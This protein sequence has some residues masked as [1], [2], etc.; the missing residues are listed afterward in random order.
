MVQFLSYEGA[1]TATDGPAAGKTSVD[2]GV[3]ETNRTAETESLQLIGA[4]TGL[5]DF[6]WTGPVPQSQGV[7]NDGQT[8]AT[9][10]VAPVAAPIATLDLGTAHIAPNPI[11]DR[12]ALS[13]PATDEP[14][15]VELYD[16]LGRRVAL[17][18]DGAAPREVEVDAR[19]LAP[20][21]YIVRIASATGAQALRVTVAR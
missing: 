3:R 14:V 16:A 12:A 6:A 1:M 8:I 21:L 20:G 4:G 11:R 10:L 13:L 17:L 2:I 19:S 9:G 5:A 15:R 7:L 18:H